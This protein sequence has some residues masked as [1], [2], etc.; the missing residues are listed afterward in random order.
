MS[1]RQQVALLGK[2][3]L[4]SSCTSRELSKIASL[5][6]EID[7]PAEK[8]LTREGEPGRECFV[9]ADG[10]MKVTLRGRRIATL[11]PGELFGEMSLLD[12]GPRAATVTAETPA[13]LYVLSPR[14]FSALLEDVPTVGRKILRTLARRLREAEKAPTH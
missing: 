1:K 12:M 5:I 2:V 3:P 9:I 13:K 6:T 4:F 14:D 8:V 10:G 7:V 11:G